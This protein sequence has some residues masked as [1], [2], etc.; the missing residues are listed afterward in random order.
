[1]VES[2]SEAI[3]YLPIFAGWGSFGSF[4]HDTIDLPCSPQPTRMDRAWSGLVFLAIIY[5][6][7]RRSVLGPNADR[8]PNIIGA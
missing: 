8:P 7:L 4:P 1:M 6:L 2:F 5:A 3:P